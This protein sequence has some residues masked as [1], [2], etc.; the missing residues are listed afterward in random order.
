MGKTL[1]LGFVMGGGYR[2]APFQV[3]HSQKPSNNK[4]STGNMIRAKKTN[5]E[6]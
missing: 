4:L 3:L 2:L 1:R 6:M 5:K